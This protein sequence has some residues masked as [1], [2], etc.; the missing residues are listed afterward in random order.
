[1][2]DVTDSAMSAQAM[3]LSRTVRPSPSKRRMASYRALLDRNGPPCLLLTTTV[4]VRG[5]GP[6]SSYTA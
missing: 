2:H 6:A 1:M 3:S 5:I 4:P